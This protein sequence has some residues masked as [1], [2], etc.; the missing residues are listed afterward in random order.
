MESGFFLLVAAGDVRIAEQHQVVDV[1]TCLKEETAHSGVG[2]RVLYKVDGA[3]M[4]VY[5]L[6]DILHLL[7]ERQFEACENLRHHLGAYVVVVAECPSGVR[8]PCLAFRLADV[9]QQRRPSEPETIYHFTIYHL[10]I[11]TLQ[12]R[13]IIKDFEGVIEDIFMPLAVF[14]LHPFEG[15]QFGE[16]ER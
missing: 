2:H 7:V 14:H 6:F 4:Q 16:D 10:V 11:C 8:V 3:H 9:M 1:I 5:H 12:F 13:Y 15:C